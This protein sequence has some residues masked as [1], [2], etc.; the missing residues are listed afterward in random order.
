MKD[1]D[2]YHRYLGR[3]RMIT[4]AATQLLRSMPSLLYG[5]KTLDRLQI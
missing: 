1:A 5:A 2:R 4:K 3:C